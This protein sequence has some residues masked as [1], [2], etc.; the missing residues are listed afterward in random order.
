M[1][2]AYSNEEY[3]LGKLASD[4]Q[5]GNRK[6][7]SMERLINSEH[8]KWAQFFLLISFALGTEFRKVTFFEDNSQNLPV[9]IAICNSGWEIL[10]III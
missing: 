2:L 3:Y 6:D 8:K 4:K 7:P 10:G 1:R 5:S 9:R